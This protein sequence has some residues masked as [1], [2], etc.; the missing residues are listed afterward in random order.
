MRRALIA[1]GTAV[2]AGAA[3]VAVPAA[4]GATGTPTCK[5]SQLSAAIGGQE[6]GAGHVYRHLVLTNKGSSACALKGFPGVSLLD[7]AGKQIGPA[8]TRESKSYGTVTIEPGGTASN[9]LHTLN[10]HGKCLPASAQ[11]R[12]YP[13]ANKASIE[14]PGE[15]TI[16]G[17]VFSISPLAAGAGGNP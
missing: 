13:P 7:S 16:C 17:N 3:V 1:V 10:R 14:I 11:V 12:V 4:A 15:I 9:T 2:A 5:T 6:A 8:A